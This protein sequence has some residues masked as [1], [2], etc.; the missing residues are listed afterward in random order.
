MNTSVEK[1]SGC[2]AGAVAGAWINTP[3]WNR[4][5]RR[6]RQP[7]LARN[8]EIIKVILYINGAEVEDEFVAYNDKFIRCKQNGDVGIANF[9][10][11][12]NN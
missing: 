1:S 9:I 8:R 5:I 2:R 10:R 7:S 11:I 6:L 4:D 12:K 3:S